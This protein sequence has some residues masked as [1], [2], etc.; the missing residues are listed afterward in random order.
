[1]NWS[2]A[3]KNHLDLNQKFLSGINKNL[4]SQ[5]RTCLQAAENVLRSA[6]ARVIFIVVILKHIMEILLCYMNPT[7]GFTCFVSLFFFH[8]HLLIN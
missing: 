5:T 3:K 8:H 4:K 7:N 2:T 1:M 6:L